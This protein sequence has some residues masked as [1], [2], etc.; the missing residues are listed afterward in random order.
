MLSS[1]GI[2]E[3]LHTKWAGRSILYKDITDST[4]NDARQL[5]IEGAAHGS[6]VVADKQE[7]GRGSNGREHIFNI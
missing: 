6:L 4:N 1:E 7:A 2:S 5:A 3:K